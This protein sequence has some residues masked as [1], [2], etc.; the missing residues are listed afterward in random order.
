M[1]PWEAQVEVEFIKGDLVRIHDGIW[2]PDLHDSS[3]VGIIIDIVADESHSYYEILLNS[4]GK[5]TL[6]GAY[7]KLLY[8]SPDENDE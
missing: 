4:G 7:L 5:V 6:H 8:E 2:E 3:R 1:G